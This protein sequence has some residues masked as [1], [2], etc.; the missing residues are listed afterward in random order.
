[1]SKIQSTAATIL[2]IL[3]GVSV[4]I[5]GLYYLGGTSDEFTG[6]KNFTSIALIW[7]VI[8]FIVAGLATLIFSFVNIF[9]N[10]RAFKNFLVVLAIA[11][12]L[13]AISY[14]LA[15]PEP[16]QSLL[17]VNIDPSSSTLKW[18]GTGLN[19]TY[20]LAVIAFIGIIASEVLRAFK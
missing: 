8:L 2:W 11:V 18:V 10:P 1:M 5:A 3:A 12:G 4:I 17:D 16:I 20:I 7:T 9:T 6:E 14:I 15:S 19:A 13:G